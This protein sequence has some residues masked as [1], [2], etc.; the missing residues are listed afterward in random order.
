MNFELW[1]YEVEYLRWDNT[2]SADALARLVRRSPRGEASQ[3][4][5]HLGVDAT[6][7]EILDK[8]E[9]FYGTV[10]S[11]VVLLQQLYAAK[12]GPD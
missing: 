4:I 7:D 6:V 8:L 11:G 1:R 2:Y 9:G 12:Q 10:E 3:L 5:L